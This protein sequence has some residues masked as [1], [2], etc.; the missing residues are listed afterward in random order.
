MENSYFLF[1]LSSVSCP[2]YRYSGLFYFLF[3]IVCLCHSFILCFTSAIYNPVGH[4]PFSN[5]ISNVTRRRRKSFLYVSVYTKEMKETEFYSV[6]FYY[7][8]LYR[9]IVVM[10]SFK[11]CTESKLSSNLLLKFL[12]FLKMCDHRRKCE[13]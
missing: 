11:N 6:V 13:K 8:L 4:S 1:F 5:F 3:I 9:T 10:I 2:L 7:L 12:E